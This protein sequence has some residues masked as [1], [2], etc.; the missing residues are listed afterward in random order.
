[1]INREQTAIG[2]QSNSKPFKSRSPPFC[3]HFSGYHYHA[4]DSNNKTKLI[5]VTL[6]EVPFSKTKVQNMNI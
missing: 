4:Y 2:R 6:K 1:M 5:I 3:F